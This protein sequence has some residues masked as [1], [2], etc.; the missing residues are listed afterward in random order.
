MTT[1]ASLSAPAAGSQAATVPLIA[2]TVPCRL[3]ETETRGPSVVMSEDFTRAR[4][5]N[6]AG[7]PVA[8]LP[9]AWPRE[10]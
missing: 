7:P 4:S 3:Q 1:R 10:V 5:S 8:P 9:A 6:P 2:S